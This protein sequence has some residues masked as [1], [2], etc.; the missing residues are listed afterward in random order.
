MGK[1][2]FT[3]I[4]L[5]G[6]IVLLGVVSVI[7]VPIV[8]DAVETSKQKTLEKQINVILESAKS[9][10]TKNTDLLPED[11]SLLLIDIE[12]LK[13]DGFLEN[14]MIVNPVTK[15]EMIGCTKITYDIDFN[16]YKY[17]YI[18]KCSN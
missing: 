5:L 16:Q 11:D 2:G 13:R 18:E 17:E 7:T 10:A 1:R 12:T 6:V 14:K 8:G 15:E 3:L 4:E 9:W